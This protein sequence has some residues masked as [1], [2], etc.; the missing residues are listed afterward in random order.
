MFLAL[1]GLMEIGEGATLVVRGARGPIVPNNSSRLLKARVLKS[2]PNL[3]FFNG[4][5]FE[6]TSAGVRALKIDKRTGRLLGARSPS[7]AKQLARVLAPILGR[8][9][10]EAQA[11][12]V[13]FVRRN[14]D[15]LAKKPSSSTPKPQTAD[16]RL[17]AADSSRRGVDKDGGEHGQGS[18]VD[19]TPRASGRAAGSQGDGNTCS[20]LSS[21]ICNSADAQNSER[22]ADNKKRDTVLEFMRQSRLDSNSFG[23]LLQGV[24]TDPAKFAGA[25]SAFTK[26]IS[27][28]LGN[29]ARSALGEARTALLTAV[30]SQAISPEAKIAVREKLSKVKFRF[31]PNFGS[32]ESIRA[33]VENCGPEGMADGA[34]AIPSIGEVVV[35][36]GILFGAAGKGGSLT[37]H[38]IHVVAHEMGH[39]CGADHVPGSPTGFGAFKPIYRAMEQCYR[40]NFTVSE[41]KFG[42]IAADTWGVEAV[43]AQLRGKSKTEA[44][45]LLADA[46]A[47][48]CNTQGSPEHPS[49]NF[50]INA[51]LGR[52]PRIREAIGCD[53]PTSE[54]PACTLKGAEPAE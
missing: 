47:P 12:M 33:F 3:I 23:N 42:E 49:G 38:L 53:G 46:F 8:F 41:E 4:K 48:L 52:N 22:L 1:L 15:A 2:A 51:T 21:S 11:V 6:R 9:S 30:E 10:G 44:I 37:N 39:H 34:F 19:T 45:Q 5:V 24:L 16:T 35:C 31:T 17:P 36:P 7:T 50:R 26:F 29:E 14:L 27:G 18:R 40:D 28:K 13:R 20:D 25:Y 32:F 43:A 54:R